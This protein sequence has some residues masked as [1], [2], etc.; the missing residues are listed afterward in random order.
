MYNHIHVVATGHSALLLSLSV[1]S[2]LPRHVF[3]QQI[4][5]V[6]LETNPLCSPMVLRQEQ[7]N[8]N[9]KHS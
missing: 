8:L 4:D 6:F 9:L 1:C 2:L 5:L 3:Q 7:L